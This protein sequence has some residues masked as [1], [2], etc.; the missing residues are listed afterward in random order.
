MTLGTWEVDKSWRLNWTEM[1]EWHDLDIQTLV[2]DHYIVSKMSGKDICIC[3]ICVAGILEL[4]VLGFELEAFTIISTVQI[5]V[6]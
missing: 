6:S 5:S 3:L 4:S 1:P 2:D